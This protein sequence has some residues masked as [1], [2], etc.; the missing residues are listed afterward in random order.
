MI[1]HLSLTSFGY[2]STL[3]LTPS[4]I[5]TRPM[6]FG[7]DYLQMIAVI[8]VMAVLIVKMLTCILPF[9]VNLYQL[10][11]GDDNISWTFNLVLCIIYCFS[12]GFLALMFPNIKSVLGLFGGLASVNICF[13]VPLV[14]YLNLKKPE[15]KWYELKN[16]IAATV[17]CTLIAFGI[18]S[19]FVSSKS[20]ILGE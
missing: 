18:V 1:I 7:V 17:F 13:L 6:P 11:Y 8:A 15:D 5:V 10:M 16:L 14:V 9:K 3:Q 19:I 12:M 4:V 20:L 2:L